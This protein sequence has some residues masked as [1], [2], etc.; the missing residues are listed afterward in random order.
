M[1][2]VLVCFLFVSAVVVSGGGVG[3]CVVVVA[4]SGGSVDVFVVVV[5]VVFV[6][7]GACVSVCI[8]FCVLVCPVSVFFSFWVLGTAPSRQMWFPPLLYPSQTWLVVYVCGFVCVCL[9]M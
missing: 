4:V 9:C 6:V 7:F 1:V 3:V 5:V 8:V 2:F